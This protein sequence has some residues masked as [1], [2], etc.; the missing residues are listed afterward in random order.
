MRSL[1]VGAML[2]FFLGETA[3]LISVADLFTSSA[4]WLG[5]GLI[6]CSA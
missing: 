6:A 5:A 3:S 1:R 2:N 4:S